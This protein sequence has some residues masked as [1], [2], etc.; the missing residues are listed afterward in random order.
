MLKS[1]SS[2][3]SATLLSRPTAKT[4]GVRATS[5][6]LTG[7][8]L[9]AQVGCHDRESSAPRGAP[10]RRCLTD[11]REECD[12]GVAFVPQVASRSRPSVPSAALL[13]ADPRRSGEESPPTSVLTTTNTQTGRTGGRRALSASRSAAF[14]SRLT[15]VRPYVVRTGALGQPSYARLA[16]NATEGNQV[17]LRDLLSLTLR[18]QVGRTLEVGAEALVAKRCTLPE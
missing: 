9:R 15:T 7:T 2:V 12:A 1:F 5:A 8:L 17:S 3:T 4:R 6:A 13:A 16:V 11:R 18:V 10:V 14:A